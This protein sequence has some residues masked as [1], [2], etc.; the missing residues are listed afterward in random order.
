[1][2]PGKLSDFT[3]GWGVVPAAFGDYGRN[4]L[5]LSSLVSPGNGDN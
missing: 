2:S 5:P 3:Y 1:M 4:V